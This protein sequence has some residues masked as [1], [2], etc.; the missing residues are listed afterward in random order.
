MFCKTL[1]REIKDK[2]NSAESYHVRQ[3]KE[4]TLFRWRFFPN[5][6][7][8]PTQSQSKTKQDFLKVETEQLILKFTWDE[9]DLK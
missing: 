2:L 6:T 7:I 4:S 3:V 5:R 9:K 8:D 1:L